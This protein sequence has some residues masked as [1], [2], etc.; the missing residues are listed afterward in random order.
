[1]IKWIGQHIVDFIARFRSDVYLENIADGTVDSDK[2]LGL[3]S[4][5]KIV[6]EAV[7][8]STVTVTDSTANTLF[9]VV[10]HDE[11]N[12]LLDDTGSFRYN[13][14]SQMLSLLSTSSASPILG[15]TNTNDDA[16]GAAL[17][18]QKIATDSAANN[19]TAGKILYFAT[20][21]N[22]AD[23]MTS[24]ISS[25]I[26]DVTNGSEAGKYNIL[27]TAN[28]STIQPGLQLTG[29]SSANEVS[30]IIGQGAAS[31]TT[32]AGNLVVSGDTIAIGAA[33]DIEPKITLTN[34]ENSVEIGIANAAN[35]MVDLSVDG[36]LVINSVGDHNIILARNDA[37]ALTIS[38]S[39]YTSLGRSNMVA[40][41]NLKAI[42]RSNSGAG[43]ALNISGGMPLPGETDTNGGNLFL[44]G[45]IGTGTGVG[46]FVKITTY[47][48]AGST[49]TGFNYSPSFQWVFTDEGEFNAPGDISLTG[50]LTVGSTAKIPT[51]QFSIPADG[52]GNV[53]GD[54]VYIGTNTGGTATSAGSIYYY[55]DSGLWIKSNSND[56]GTA[57][58]WLAVALGADPDVDGMLVRGMVDLGPNIVGTEALGSIIYLDKATAGAATTAAPTA[59]GDIVRVI[60][61]AVSTGDA[62]KIWFSPD[63]TWVEHV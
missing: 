59:T 54:V 16:N 4:N 19:D 12:A 8:A 9:P 21:D 61:Y 22:N 56:P 25:Q 1:M 39:G 32:V 5:N 47:P 29:S 24:A 28:G 14:S 13:P 42:Q 45:G 41:V 7:S 36:D 33:T 38:S 58:G 11:S 57:T 31:V 49:G 6:K 18:F 34:D 27:V 46:G 51:R 10:F 44:Q 43:K 55:A 62:N 37:Q 52:A 2:F 63:N 30:A 23:I 26:V 20:N 15:L 60:G 40:Q 53:D 3:D 48:P 17:V 50:A 35:D